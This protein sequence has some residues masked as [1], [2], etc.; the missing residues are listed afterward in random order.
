VDERD[1]WQE[2][3]MVDVGA[4]PSVFRAAPG[5]LHESPAANFTATL[6][7][8]LGGTGV[9]AGGVLLATAAGVGEEARSEIL[10]PGAVTL[11]VGA[12]MLVAGAVLGYLT[13]GEKRPSATT[14]WTPS[15]TIGRANASSIGMR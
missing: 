14:Q 12:G 3:F 4:T 10:T 5:Y 13:R 6:L 8:V 7:L 1:D 15:Q 2:D 9:F 11:G